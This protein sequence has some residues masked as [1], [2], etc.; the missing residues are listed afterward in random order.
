VLFCQQ[1]K[2]TCQQVSEMRIGQMNEKKYDPEKFDFWQMLKDSILLW[3]FI[4]PATIIWGFL[5]GVLGY[6]F[7]FLII[8][9]IFWYV[10]SYVISIIHRKR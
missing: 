3:I 5:Q 10:I 1:R 6:V 7:G 2:G 8:L 4:I 9:S